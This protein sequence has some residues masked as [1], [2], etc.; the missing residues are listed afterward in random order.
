MIMFW[1]AEINPDIY[2]QEYLESSDTTNRQ[3]N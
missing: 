3:K 1:G 2:N